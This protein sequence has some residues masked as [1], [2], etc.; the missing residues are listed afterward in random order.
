[1]DRLAILAGGAVGAATVTAAVT[2][3]GTPEAVAVALLATGVWTGA[4]SRS[5]Q[6]EFLDAFFA[7]AL[8]W[9]LAVTLVAFA[10][11]GTST[12]NEL[13][14]SVVDVGLLAYL[15]AL[16]FS[17]VP[18]LCAAAGGGAGARIQYV[19]RDRLGA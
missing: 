17:V 18:G 19:V 13:S 8:G 7:G 16:G 14:Q 1:M 4:V 5:F 15:S 3:A 2:R 6:S 9:A 12:A 11:G 10:F